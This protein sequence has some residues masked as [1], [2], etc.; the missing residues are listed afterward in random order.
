MKVKCHYDLAESVEILAHHCE[1]GLNC[2]SE[3]EYSYTDANAS[4]IEKEMLEALEKE[5]P[6][7]A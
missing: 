1:A 2:I 7:D 3:C 6:V 4:T 5:Y